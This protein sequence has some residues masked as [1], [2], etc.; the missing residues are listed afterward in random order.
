MHGRRYDTWFSDDPGSPPSERYNYLY[1][2]EE[3]SSP[4]AK[5]NR[6]RGQNRENHLRRHQ[7]IILKQ[8]GIVN[9]LQLIN[10]LTGNKVKILETLRIHYPR[11]EAIANQPAMELNSRSRSHR[12]RRNIVR[13]TKIEETNPDTQRDGQ[14]REDGKNPYF[15][16]RSSKALRA[17]L[18][19]PGFVGA[20]V[21]VA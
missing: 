19:R 3:T 10:L 13:C 21:A 20:G 17:S 6:A 15:L 11:L 4:G 9:A 1:T 7:A 8:K 5:R 14:N 16:K 18:G 12:N 2:E